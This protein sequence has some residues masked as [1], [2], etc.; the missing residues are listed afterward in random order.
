MATDLQV[1]ITGKDGVSRI[2]KEISTS[3]KTAGD[4]V[5]AAGREGE[6]GLKKIDQ[7]AKSADRS[8]DAVG[9]SA[10]RA[11]LDMVAIG[12]AVGTAA[13]GVAQLGDAFRDQERQISGINQLYGDQAADLL[14]LTEGIQDYTRYS[15]DAARE[16]ALF[17]SSLATN[18]DLTADQIGVLIE[19]SADL[20]QVFGVDLVDAATRTSGA[21]RGEGE[22]AERLGLNLSDAAVAARALD[23]GIT[24]WN[25][26][27]ALTESEKAAFRFQ[28]FLEDTEATAG[29]AAAA[30]DNAGGRFRE[31]ANEMQD[32]AQS[33][34]GFLG[35][36]GQVAA[37]MAPLSLALP[38]VG[39]GL[40]KVAV[41]MRAAA[42]A[43]R[44]FIATPIGLAITVTASALALASA[45]WIKNRNDASE[46]VAAWAEAEAAA[47]SL[48]EQINQL[49]LSGDIFTSRWARTFQEDLGGQFDWFSDQI[50]GLSDD[51]RL[52]ILRG[53]TDGLNE[54]WTNVVNSTEFP[55]NPVLRE[56]YIASLMPTADDSER[57]SAAFTQLLSLRTSDQI[58]FSKVQV[59][60][61]ALFA[62][63][64]QAPDGS[65]SIDT[66]ITQLEAL[67]AEQLRYVEGLSA[68]EQATLNL[69][70][71]QAHWQALGAGSIGAM[72]EEMAQ[73]EAA[74]V[75]T[76]ESTRDAIATADEMA[77]AQR[78]AMNER[79]EHEREAA[80][81]Q[82]E[83][84]AAH[85]QLGEEGR[86][87]DR[88]RFEERRAQAE[89]SRQALGLVASGYTAITAE[90]ERAAASAAAFA[91]SLNATKDAAAGL[92]AE[93]LGQLHQAQQDFLADGDN[94]L[95]F[96]LQYQETSV[97][98]M[99]DALAATEGI[100]AGIGSAS[101]ALDAWV[102]STYTG[103]ARIID[104]L[105]A[106]RAGT[107]DIGAGFAAI[108]GQ[109]GDIAGVVDG[110]R[111]G[112]EGA[113]EG[114]AGIRSEVGALTAAALGL[115]DTDPGRPFRELVI[116]ARDLENVSA[117]L[118]SIL[119]TFGQID[120]LGQR[121]SSAGSIAD[122][123]FGEDG[124]PYDA[125]G[126]LRDIYDAGR[127]G[128][129][130]FNAT[131]QAG[132]S[133]Q[134]DNVRVQESLNVIRAT[135]LP[136]LAQEQAAYEAQIREISELGA[137]EQRRVLALQD[138]AV[139]TE[140]ASNYATA[141]SASLG[142][143]PEEVASNIIISSAEAD[144]VIKDLLLQ[145]ELIEIDRE[146]NIK[147]NFPDGPTV[148]DS[149][150]ELTDS[151]DQLIRTLGG[152]PPIHIDEGNARQVL[153]RL[154]EVKDE[155]GA[156]DGTSA[157]VSV[158]ANTIDAETGLTNLQQL[159]ID[160]G[161]L[162]PED[163]HIGADTADAEVGLTS[164]QQRLVDLGVLRVQDI[165]ITATD[166]ATPVVEGLLS[167]LGE[168]DAMTATAILNAT[169]NASGVTRDAHGVIRS[170][171]SVVGTGTL[172]AIDNASGKSRAA[173]SVIDSMTGKSVNL[174]AVDLASGVAR[175][176]RG[177][178]DA[179]Q[180]KSVTITTNYRA[181][182][183]SQG[184]GP[185]AEMHGGI[186]GYALG[187]NV[188]PIWAGEGDN[189]EIAHFA[190]GGSAL[191]PREGLYNVP[192]GTFIEP[193]NSARASISAPGAGGG[194]T[195]HIHVAGSVLGVDDFLDRVIPELSTVVTRAVSRQD[196][197]LGVTR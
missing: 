24:N 65:V 19:R 2:F 94:I 15:N 75:R 60:A 155:A 88:A 133:I 16:A 99:T 181:V 40:G 144:P 177:A 6:T 62:A 128:Q 172:N 44:A 39:A 125:V 130:Q 42:V 8:L 113:G 49:A 190:T 165:S 126:P 18:Y 160:L 176:I 31:F 73:Y 22:A 74:V 189:P 30:A 135:Q 26:A 25:V 59:E 12:A 154:R 79:G 193:S 164:L 115:S 134:E 127:I 36:V 120:S 76:T 107:D 7:A 21:I 14:L 151:I 45:A 43:S 183:S 166:E 142:E 104:S 158:D 57:L 80:A 29:S 51:M 92:A 20:A 118:D 91:E 77:Q 110:V 34:G 56:N 82:D 55:D 81:A 89:Q 85:R 185:T 101:G 152:I 32:A 194:V 4:A 136:L 58:D 46:S 5:E 195:V 102:D 93:Q 1:I 191:I 139:Q 63:F 95:D 71:A 174:V 11:S 137:V 169:D 138:Q 27:G 72:T 178:I 109:A 148:Q 38:L 146:G 78:E 17:A 98:A 47:S 145:M 86:E 122:A 112:V 66:L 188:V 141:Y 179:I 106:V 10:G 35:P 149:I 103:N 153:D 53:E 171:D 114:I 186:A 119:N 175:G 48:T 173:Q 84:W 61:D 192:A 147:V 123:L 159:L 168:A 50:S 23:A 83:Y 132:I 162:R 161:V 105:A 97:N 129:E 121:S 108:P 170:T 13:G 156:L 180:G 196:R 68:T 140:I 67:Y 3:A 184:R 70:S 150:S 167:E 9:K 182:Y 117:G 187:G 111:V 131:V 143:I 116:M 124:D 197:S 87:A 28:L 163:I 69:A 54:F 52:A 100:E 157:N 37:E 33:A 96:W 90:Q 64:D 41:G